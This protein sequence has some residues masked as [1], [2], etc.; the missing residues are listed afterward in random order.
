MSVRA[1]AWKKYQSRDSPMEP[2]D[3]IQLTGK[4]ERDDFTWCKGYKNR[5]WIQ[6]EHN[7]MVDLMNEDWFWLTYINLCLFSQFFALNLL[8]IS[9]SYLFFLF[10]KIFL[11]KLYHVGF[12]SYIFISSYFFTPI[13]IHVIRFWNSTSLI[14]PLVSHNRIRYKC[15]GPIENNEL[16]HNTNQ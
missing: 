14:I 9:H 11:N 1:L 16:G 12:S 4:K 5:V 3:D 13:I 6:K 2:R 15:Y 8:E 7:W 10:S